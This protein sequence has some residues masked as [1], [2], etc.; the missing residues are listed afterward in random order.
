MSD[1]ND[2]PTIKISDPH[3]VP[4]TFIGDVGGVGFLNG[5]INIT[6]VT[7]RFTPSA[8]RV[9]NDLVVSGRHRLDLYCAQRLYEMLGEI[10]E[11]NTKGPAQ[12]AVKA[13]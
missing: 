10:I 9:D 7:P 13:N 1:K 2:L 4:V 5:V 11:A 6:Y 3:N 8:N 12:P